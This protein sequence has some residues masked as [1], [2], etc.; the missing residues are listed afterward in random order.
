[1]KNNTAA[2]RYV[3]ASDLLTNCARCFAVPAA[4][5]GSAIEL[6]R[7][8]DRHALTCIAE[9]RDCDE[10]WYVERDSQ[11]GAI[12]PPSADVLSIASSADMLGL[13]KGLLRYDV[14]DANGRSVASFRHDDADGAAD[15]VVNPERGDAKPLRMVPVVCV[16]SWSR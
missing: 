14:I 13:A 11:T 16:A 4:W 10:G 2:V 1:M 6:L 15:R 9:Y 12:T 3:I 7:Y 8:A 5:V